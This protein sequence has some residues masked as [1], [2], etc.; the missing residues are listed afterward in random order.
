MVNVIFAIYKSF[1]NGLMNFMPSSISTSH[2]SIEPPIWENT[3][4]W[5]LLNSKFL[6]WILMFT[7]SKGLCVF[8]Y[9]HAYEFIHVKI[10]PQWK[11]LFIYLKNIFKSAI[12]AEPMLMKQWDID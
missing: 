5:I 10:F 4:L 6:H 9:M 3:K 8:M 11:K 12:G 2:T 7:F 1:N